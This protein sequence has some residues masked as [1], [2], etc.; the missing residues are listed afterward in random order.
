MRDVTPGLTIADLVE[1]TKKHCG[2][3][4]VRLALA[5]GKDMGEITIVGIIH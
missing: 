4:N 1:V 2:I 5:R 3:K